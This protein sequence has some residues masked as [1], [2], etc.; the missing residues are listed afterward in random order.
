MFGWPH[1]VL[2]LAA[3]RFPTVFGKYTDWIRFQCLAWY[4]FSAESNSFIWLNAVGGFFA[5]HYIYAL[6]NY[7]LLRLFA[8]NFYK[9]IGFAESGLLMHLAADFAVHG[10]PVVVASRLSLTPA[11]WYYWLYTGVPHATYCYALTGGWDPKPLYGFSATEF[12]WSSNGVVWL[13]VLAGHATAGALHPLFS[14]G[15]L[16]KS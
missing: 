6:T 3:K 1:V 13:A 16:N 8:G 11:K 14:F 4:F 9:R 15:S 10:L 12:G 2:F 7:E 5:I